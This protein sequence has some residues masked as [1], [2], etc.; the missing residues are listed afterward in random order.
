MLSFFYNMIK[1]LFKY[2]GS[3]QP[4]FQDYR[5]KGKKIRNLFLSFWY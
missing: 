2:V 1:I 5:K 4:I 3:F